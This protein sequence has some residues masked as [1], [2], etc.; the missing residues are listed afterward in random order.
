MQT[1]FVTDRLLKE[2]T[3]L[4]GKLINGYHRSR[5]PKRVT[6]KVVCAKYMSNKILSW[7]L[8]TDPT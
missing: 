4:A 7:G 2:N 3:I 8:S 1:A 6:I 5:G